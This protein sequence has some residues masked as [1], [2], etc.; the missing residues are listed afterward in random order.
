MKKADIVKDKNR[1]N[2]IIKKGFYTKNN[3]FVIYYIN[4]DS[5][6]PKFGIAVG[7]KIGNA[8]LRNKYKR[9]IRSIIDNNNFL[10]PKN[11]DYIIIMKKACLDLKFLDMQKELID[12]IKKIKVTK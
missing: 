7:T 4:K 12:L 1:F 8:V 6:N 2:D 3:Y 10:F 9:R 5:F 11:K